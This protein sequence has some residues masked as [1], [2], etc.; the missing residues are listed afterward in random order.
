MTRRKNN[1]ETQTVNKGTEKE[2]KPIKD[3][4]I[5]DRIVSLTNAMFATDTNCV[6]LS[7][8]ILK[9]LLGK[10]VSLETISAFNRN[11]RKENVNL[12]IIARE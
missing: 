7:R 2:I 1:A 10:D 8:S 12:A 9:Y 5:I 11:Q 6:K 3:R 4:N